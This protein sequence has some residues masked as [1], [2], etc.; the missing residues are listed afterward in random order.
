VIVFFE[1]KAEFRDAFRKAVLANA[2]ASLRDEPGC[3]TF[4]VCEDAKG[5]CFLYEL[6]TSPEAFQA[7]LAMPHFKSFDAQCR[8][9]GVSKRVHRYE[10][11]VN[12]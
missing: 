10:R 7:H 8:E 2:A 3:V 5:E 1:V 12:A 9:W 11:L 4:D 6:Y